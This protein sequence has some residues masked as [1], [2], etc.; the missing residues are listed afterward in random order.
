MR[1]AIDAR[2]RRLDVGR[3]PEPGGGIARAG[4]RW[5][6]CTRWAGSRRRAAPEGAAISN[7]RAAN[8]PRFIIRGVTDQPVPPTVSASTRSVGWP[9]PTGTD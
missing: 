3:K 5:I 1:S 9:T 4:T 6:R 8:R 2:Y 7:K